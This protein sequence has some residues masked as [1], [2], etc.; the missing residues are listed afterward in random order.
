MSKSRPVFEELD[1]EKT[2]IEVSEM[3]E[4]WLFC[5]FQVLRNARISQSKRDF[6]NWALKIQSLNTID[7]DIVPAITYE[8]C[9]FSLAEANHEQTRLHL[10]SW[11]ENSKDPY[12][13]ARK[14]SVHAELGNLS[15]AKNLTEKALDSLKRMQKQSP[16]VFW[17]LSREGW[18]LR[19]LWQI[20]IAENFEYGGFKNERERE[21]EAYRCSPSIELNN[22]IQKIGD[23]SLPS[24]PTVVTA[25]KPEFDYGSRSKTIGY[26]ATTSYERLAPALNFLNAV[27]ISGA[28]IQAE[29]VTF[30]K[31]EFFQSLQWI[32][33]D[34]P[35]LWA[36]LIFR[37]NGVGI[38]KKAITRTTLSKLSLEQTEQLFKTA[39]QY[40]EQ[41]FEDG[42]SENIKIQDRRF[43]SIINMCDF[44]A[45]ISLR[46]G[47]EQRKWL[48]A[49]ALKLANFAAMKDH[50]SGQEL[51]S[52]LLRRSIPY[53]D[54]DD[55]RP[56]LFD[57]ANFPLS[58]D[59]STRFN[60]VR[61][62]EPYLFASRSLN[63]ADWLPIKGLKNAINQ[64][65]KKAESHSIELRTN[66]ILRLTYMNELR[67]LNEAENKKFADAVWRQQDDFNLPTLASNVYK[68]IVLSLPETEKDQASTGLL[69]LLEKAF[70]ENRF[71]ETQTEIDG[72]LKK[73]L[74]LS[75]KD[76]DLLLQLLINLKW[77]CEKRKINNP[78]FFK[79]EL[80]KRYLNSILR[81][82]NN[83]CDRF[84]RW[85]V[86]D[87]YQ[88]DNLFERTD[89]VFDVL[90]NC[91]LVY[92]NINNRE[93][94]SISKMLTEMEELGIP[95]AKAIPVMA[96]I[97]P[98]EQTEFLD[99]L[100]FGL[101]SDI[102]DNAR[103]YCYACYTW[104]SNA[105]QL[106]LDRLSGD[107]YSTLLNIV[108]GVIQP[109]AYELMGVMTN[110][111]RENYY[112]KNDKEQKKLIS[113]IERASKI[114]A[115]DRED[116]SICSRPINT[117]ELP[118]LRR[119]FTRLIQVLIEKEYNTN[120]N[121]QD[122]IEAARNDPFV[123]VRSQFD[124]I[125]D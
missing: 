17:T 92:G 40:V 46:L 53:F 14:A 20:N 55:I 19:L 42:E 74:S 88:S 115:Y 37:F 5:A 10:E 118:H 96:A 54:A 110:L 80:T 9:L 63:N 22:L 69:N 4:A 51:V 45:R 23:R 38:G 43:F 62:P 31:E 82:W 50:P 77:Y 100:H 91:I 13:L 71:E 79:P 60:Y 107:V 73:R 11:P 109:I 121:I 78:P 12:W 112:P 24:K 15:I 76:P 65:I 28:L 124:E 35:Q 18:C 21:L 116:E 93:K 8:Q 16:K 29:N 6:E 58:G 36:S 61:W 68:S 113:A 108:G 59:F 87:M 32:Q 72:E 7:N 70:V 39:T 26:S 81:W 123:D 94:K 105:K 27:E 117:D 67:L 48:F 2:L 85:L 95:M 104:E 47:T 114:L 106:K 86:R 83:E 44:T 75:G 125:F 25:G 101:L 41:F 89:L 102:A 98:E 103:R 84:R 122:W 119:N 97:E 49:V 57:M 56:L 64:L 120:R 34:F 1:I 52:D 90:A 111:V 66:S 30:E 3:K 99:K 33:D